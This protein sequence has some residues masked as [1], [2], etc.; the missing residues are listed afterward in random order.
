MR[1]KSLQ[2]WGHSISTVDPEKE[3]YKVPPL[4][5]LTDESPAN[6]DEEREE[7]P[8]LL[9]LAFSFFVSGCIIILAGAYLYF[10]GQLT[11]PI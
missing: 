9:L 10:Q 6:T 4:G 5:I 11:L 1:L 3:P 7:L 8:M 2:N